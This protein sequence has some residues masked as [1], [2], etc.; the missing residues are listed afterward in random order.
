MDGDFR[1]NLYRNIYTDTNVSVNVG[2]KLKFIN[3]EQLS[4]RVMCVF[5]IRDS[6]SP[7]LNQ[8]F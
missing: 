8:I 4:N 1:V 6:L 7:E 2:V 3:Q 5:L